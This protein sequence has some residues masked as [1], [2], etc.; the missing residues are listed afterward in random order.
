MF[1]LYNHIEE[2]AKQH[3]FSSVQELCNAAGVWASSLS[4]LNNGRSKS[5]SM[6][7][8]KKLA[9]ALD[10]SIDAV[11]GRE[12]EMTATSGDGQQSLED[13]ISDKDKRLLEWFRSL[14]EEKQNA[15]LISQDAPKEVF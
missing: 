5:I 12:K 9:A 15:I 2:L 6:S 14:P 10:V 13:S 1:N 7:T 8:A 3:G 11:Y 4:N